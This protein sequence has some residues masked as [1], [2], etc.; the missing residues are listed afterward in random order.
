[1][2]RAGAQQ[3]QLTSTP[4]VESTPK[5][6]PG[7]AQVVFT[8]HNPVPS[9]HDS[10]LWVMN[11][12]GS[13]QHEVSPPGL[14]NSDFDPAWSP[15]GTKI[16]F[17][18]FSDFFGAVLTINADGSG[19]TTV[20]A[21]PDPRFDTPAW[22]PDGTQIAYSYNFVG[23]GG[24]FIEVVD[25]NGSSGFELTGPHDDFEPGAEHQPAWSPDGTQIAFFSGL[26]TPPGINIATT[27]GNAT[28]IFVAIGQ[29]PSW[30]P[31]GQRIAF[32]RDGSVWTMRSDGTQQVILTE[33][34]EPN[35]AP[36]K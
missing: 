25:L 19:L 14:F 15:D 36:K 23:P 1:M 6:S 27:T 29:S 7:G 8:R 17:V 18:R 33:G 5:L 20:V 34:D 13:G 21:G 12:D 24:N 4:E 16:V 22:S 9:L 35:W 26:S 31:E 3:T 30:S 32:S 10:T 11:A 2:N 28:P